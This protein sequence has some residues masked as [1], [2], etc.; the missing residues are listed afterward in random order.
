MNKSELV[1]ATMQKEEFASRAAAERAVQAV[2]DS[3]KEG[4][5]SGGLQLVGFGTFSITQKRERQGRNPQTGEVITIPAKK[6]VKY[7]AASAI[8][9]A[10]NA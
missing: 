6:A 3:M 1:T 4:I 10:I 5:E 7:N 8:T 2:L 9:Q